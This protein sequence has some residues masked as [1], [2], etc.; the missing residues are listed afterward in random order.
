MFKL[1]VLLLIAFVSILSA[2]ATE[3]VWGN[4]FGLYGGLNLNFHRSN[5]S[6]RFVTP[7][8]FNSNGVYNPVTGFGG[9]EGDFQLHKYIVA[10]GR[11]GLNWAG[12]DYDVVS[13]PNISETMDNSLMYFDI[14]PS[15]K[16]VN[17]I[18]KCERFYFTTGVHFSI[19]LNAQFEYSRKQGNSNQMK[20]DNI[21][22]AGTQITI[23]IGIGYF[24]KLSD[25]ISII[26]ELSYNINTSKLSNNDIWKDCY[27]SQIKCGISIVTNF[28]VFKPEEKTKNAPI[29]L[30]VGM[31]GV[32]YK[33]A[34]EKR[35]RVNQIRLEDAEFGEYIPLVPYIFFDV[36]DATLNSKYVTTAKM[37]M[38]G[39]M[40]EEDAFASSADAM[41]VNNKILDITGK[42][43]QK[44]PT[45]N[46]T[47]TGTIDGKNE[48]DGVLSEKRAISVRKYLM[49][50][51]SIDESR[52]A[53]QY[54]KSPVK[55]SAQ[56]VP[57]GIAENRRVE[58]SSNDS[59]IL[60]PIFIKGE[61]VKIAEPSHIIFA[62]SVKS[63]KDITGWD[64][65]IY[66]A[67]RLVKKVSSNDVLSRVEEIT[68]DIQ[69]NDLSL[70]QLPLEYR[71]TAFVGDSSRTYTGYINMDYSA[72][73]RKKA[74]EQADRTITKYSLILFDFDSPEVTAT[75][76]AVI[77]KFIVP[78]IS[79]GST[80]DIFGYTDKIGQAK[81]N[82]Q[83]ATERAE[84]VK[85][86][87]QTKNRNV[88]INA[89][90]IGADETIF[91]NNV[92]IG[93]QLSR[94][95]QIL[96]VTPKK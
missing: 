35:L 24:Y 64:F 9:L 61:N 74:I 87:I 38:S 83:L 89:Y 77:D 7:Y 57:E 32:Y 21:E 34:N 29:N 16:F 45:A 49:D 56:S 47:L 4:N 18:P 1:K 13:S 71:Y 2:N 63:E 95:V 19:P 90:G 30:N 96:I 55:P 22:G 11:L 12:V 54:G 82:K 79:F 62:P 6:T 41:S 46:L 40:T 67:D 39:G 88:K 59:R 20:S 37:D 92:P 66:Q 28:S 93:R 80:I 51:H 75:N 65:E 23:P 25:N 85:E 72:V 53:L 10:T 60:E 48:K 76:K 91:D 14:A 81:Y 69:A 8:V 58:I 78:A 68:W 33:D 15:I 17:L 42:R 31:E 50:R 5:I 52:V 43:L 94:T 70:S 3:V 36:N 73:E 27:F 44:Y 86:Y 26:P 84:A